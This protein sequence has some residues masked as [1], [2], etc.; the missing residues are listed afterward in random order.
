MASSTEPHWASSALVVIDVQ[1]DFLDDG[2]LPVPGTR[3]ILPAL[4][5]LMAAYRAADLPIVHVVRLYSGDDVDTVRRD[6]L[7]SGELDAARPGSPGSQIPDTVA[8]VDLEPSTLLAGQFQVVAGDE[9]ILFKPR[10]SAFHRTALDP[11]LR[12]REVDTVVIAGCNLPNCPRATAFDATSLDYRVVL[13]QDATSGGTPERLADLERIG[14]IR[15][16]AHEVAAALPGT[17]HEVSA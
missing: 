4:A 16:D 10:W 14:V 3:D 13:A 2:A 6:E 17:Q 11:W 5:D 8:E 9:V 12:E 1:N 15:R 7:T